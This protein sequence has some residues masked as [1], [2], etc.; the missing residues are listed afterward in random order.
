MSAQDP[1]FPDLT[2]FRPALRVRRTRIT[3]FSEDYQQPA[4]PE[5]CAQPR[6]IPEWLVANRFSHRQVIHILQQCGHKSHKDSVR[7]LRA[8]KREVQQTLDYPIREPVH[9]VRQ[10]HLWLGPGNASLPTRRAYWIALEHTFDPP[11]QFRPG[12]LLRE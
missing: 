11:F 2:S 6:R 3:A 12:P 8:A 4:A 9:P 5:R 10:A 1:L 7:L